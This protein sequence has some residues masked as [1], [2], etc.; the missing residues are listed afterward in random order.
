VVLKGPAKVDRR[1]RKKTGMVNLNFSS[2]I[3]NAI[4]P[5]AVKKDQS[6]ICKKKNNKGKAAKASIK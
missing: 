3:K 2:N 1:N 6:L 4:K 5:I